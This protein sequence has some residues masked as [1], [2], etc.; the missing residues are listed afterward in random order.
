MTPK[1]T[2]EVSGMKERGMWWTYLRRAVAAS[3]VPTRN[4]R[5]MLASFGV[6]AGFGLIGG[7]HRLGKEPARLSQDVAVAAVRGAVLLFVVF[8]LVTVTMRFCRLLW[9]HRRDPV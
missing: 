5:W 8:W 7:L 2:L 6:G 3:C 9:T 1:D 4:W